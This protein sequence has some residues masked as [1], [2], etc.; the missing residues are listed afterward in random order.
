[1]R[2]RTSDPTIITPPSENVT[3]NPSPTSLKISLS[4]GIDMP[5][6]SGVAGLMPMGPKVADPTTEDT[7][8]VRVDWGADAFVFSRSSVRMA[9]SRRTF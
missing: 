7:C 6:L 1:M 4:L 5:T 3:V 2:T 9:F 8:C